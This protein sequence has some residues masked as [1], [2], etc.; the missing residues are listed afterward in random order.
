MIGL[1]DPVVYA[2]QI[3][4]LVFCTIQCCLAFMYPRNM[5]RNFSIKLPV[6]QTDDIDDNDV[7]LGTPESVDG[8]GGEDKKSHNEDFRV[9]VNSNNNDSRNSVVIDSELT[10]L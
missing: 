1:N 2:P 10:E 9:D 3:V 7:E 8:G 5:T 6:G 4:G